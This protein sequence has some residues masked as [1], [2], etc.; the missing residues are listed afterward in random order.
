MMCRV[1]RNQIANSRRKKGM[2]AWLFQSVPQEYDLRGA[3]REGLKE[4]WR[5]SRYRS[6]MK[7][8]DLVFFWMGGPPDV[9]GLYGWGVIAGVPSFD[10]SDKQF[11]VEVRYHRQLENPLLASKIRGAPALRQMLI[12]R[13]P[14]GTNFALSPLE[15]GALVDLLPPSERPRL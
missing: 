1:L 11:G 4:T 5:V 8:G 12:F 13:A 10:P 9:R 15:A 2:N 3:L 14:F 7:P 6:Q